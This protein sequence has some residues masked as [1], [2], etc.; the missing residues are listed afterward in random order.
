MHCGIIKT[1]VVPSERSTEC[2]LSPL[3][4]ENFKFPISSFVKHP[5]CKP[6]SQGPLYLK[7]MEESLISFFKL[8]VELHRS[9]LV[10]DVH[11]LSHIEQHE[12]EVPWEYVWCADD[13]P[14]PERKQHETCNHKVLLGK[15]ICPYVSNP[16]EVIKITFIHQDFN[17]FKPKAV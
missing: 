15:A 8:G 7:G 4:T 14:C 6:W 1:S 9:A 3:R 13:V 12:A 2:H 5:D 16:L 17:P 11:Q 10:Y